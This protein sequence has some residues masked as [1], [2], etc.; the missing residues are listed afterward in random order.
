ATI[1]EAQEQ[2]DERLRSAFCEAMSEM[3]DLGYPGIS[4]PRLRGASKLNAEESLAH[5]SAVSF[6]IDVDSGATG[7]LHLPEAHNGLGYQNLISMVFQ[8][9]RFRD[10]WMRIGKERLR[11]HEN[12]IAP[13]HLVLIEE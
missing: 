4:N 1:A 5:D 10:K 13:I 6:I 12:E 8:L 7:E 9:M 11:D 2:F 3:E